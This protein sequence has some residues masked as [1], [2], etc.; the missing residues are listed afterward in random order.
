ML[1]WSSRAQKVTRRGVHLDIAGQRIDY[2]NDDLVFNYL[3]NR[4][5]TAMT[6]TI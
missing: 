3:A 1:M 2:W 4:S 5:I 6:R